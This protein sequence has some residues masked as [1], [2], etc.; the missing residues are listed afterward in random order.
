MLF[1]VRR[2]TEIREYFS[3]Y[4]EVGCT[5]FPKPLQV[6]HRPKDPNIGI[7][8]VRF[9]DRRD[10]DAALKDI[11]RKIVELGGV[12]LKGEYTPPQHWPS[13]TTRRYF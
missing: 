2:T 10:A 7:G 9:V 5:Y 13:E 4:G 6:E 1:T 11:N 3:K 12:I 8:Y